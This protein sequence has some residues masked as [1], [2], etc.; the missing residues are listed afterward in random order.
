MNGQ[1]MNRSGHYSLEQ[2]ADFLDGRLPEAENMA[3]RMHLDS[4]C[5][6]CNSSLAFLIKIRGAASVNS[7]QAPPKIIHNKMVREFTGRENQHG[8]SSIRFLRW[9]IPAAV[10]LVFIAIFTFNFGGVNTAYAASLTH[11]TG[12]IEMRLSPGGN[13]VP[14]TENQSFPEQAE[15]RAGAD[16]SATIALPNGTE[17]HVLPGSSIQLVRLKNRNGNWEAVMNQSSGTMQFV[18]ANETGDL[19]ILTQAGEISANQASF[20]VAINQDGSTLVN[21]DEGDVDAKSANGTIHIPKGK[22]ANLQVSCP[23]ETRE[24]KPTKNVPGHQKPTCVPTGTNG[25]PKDPVSTEN[26]NGQDSKGN[27]VPTPQE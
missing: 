12:T 23:A 6:L 1:G 14:V 26:N 27:P 18:A 2:L 4:G 21:V 7:W 13:W 16:G 10:A 11:V 25:Q 22:S 3:A 17:V 19:T 15:I 5:E 24:P 20:N 8:R 9:L